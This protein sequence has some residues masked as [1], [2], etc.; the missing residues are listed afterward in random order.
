MRLRLPPRFLNLLLLVFGTS[1]GL[2][3][4]EALVRR[5]VPQEHA[6]STLL[7]GLYIP[8][9]KI[10]YVLAPGFQRHVETRKY[11]I[12]VDISAL[13]LRERPIPAKQTD[14]RRILAL[15]DSFTFGIHAGPP[16]ST[17]VKKLELVVQQNT[18]QQVE[19]I[20]LYGSM[21]LAPLVGLSDL[22]VDLVESGNTL[23]AN[24]LVPLE[25]VSDISSRLV[26]NKA[27]WKMKHETIKALVESLAEVING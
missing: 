1:V 18:L 26:V 22:I 9:P 2:L 15:G 4:S 5:F 6:L 3:L 21:E 13:G 11:D 24:G 8:H 7:R 12:D 27:S 20:K 14:V 16:E 17:Y 25:F 23:K 10:G 19:I